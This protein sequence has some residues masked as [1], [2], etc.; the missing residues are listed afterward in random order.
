MLPLLLLVLQGPTTRALHFLPLPSLKSGLWC[1]KAQ[2]LVGLLGEF[3]RFASSPV[4]SPLEE[5][6]SLRQCYS[7]KRESE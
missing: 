6:A 1:P 5:L 3:Q 4:V 2:P 7:L